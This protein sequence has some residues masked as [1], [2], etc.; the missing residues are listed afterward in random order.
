MTFISINITG[1]NESIQGLSSASS[2][3]AAARRKILD[4]ASQYM[5]GEL[6]RN[7]HVI[8][9][10]MRNSVHVASITDKQAV[11]SVS[12]PYAVY[13]NARKGGTQGPHDF[14]DRSEDALRG[15][16]PDMI[17]THM[18]EL[19]TKTI[20]RPFKY[21]H[22]TIGKGGRT[23]YHYSP[24]TRSTSGFRTGTYIDSGD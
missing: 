20:K 23:I 15:V 1:L 14:A 18:A 22:K 5:V 21:T 4:Q 8:T 6:K 9:G 12:A 13:E 3:L 24:Y 2:G 17:Q 7:A 19:F 10:D 16:L 11:V